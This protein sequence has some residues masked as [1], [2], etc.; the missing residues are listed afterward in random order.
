VGIAEEEMKEEVNLRPPPIVQDCM[1]RGN[2]APRS[3]RRSEFSGFSYKPTVPCSLPSFLSLPCAAISSP[4]TLSH[5]FPQISLQSLK[6]SGLL[7][8]ASGVIAHCPYLKFMS[9]FCAA[10]P[11]S[12]TTLRERDLQV[13]H[14]F[15]GTLQ[16]L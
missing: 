2:L 11:S 14:F 5:S 15:V 9:L 13:P 3:G 7:M 4:H 12:Q 1:A 6:T 8:D 16:P 10:C